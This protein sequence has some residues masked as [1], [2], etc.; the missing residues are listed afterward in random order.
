[1]VV[2]SEDGNT[3]LGDGNIDIVIPTDPQELL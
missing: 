3:E 2:N 1:M